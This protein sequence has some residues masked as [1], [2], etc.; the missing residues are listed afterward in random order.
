MT[1]E[2]DG[3]EDNWQDTPEHLIEAAFGI[4]CNV[5]NG[6]WRSGL[7]ATQRLEW[8]EAAARWMARWG[9]MSRAGVIEGV[10]VEAQ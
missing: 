6:M 9:R 3:T 7:H 5:D 8:R 10:P 1:T 4:I 2:P